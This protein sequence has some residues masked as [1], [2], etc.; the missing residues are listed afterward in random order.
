MPEPATAPY[1]GDDDHRPIDWGGLEVTPAPPIQG[2]EEPVPVE[3]EGIQYT[4]G[5]QVQCPKCDRTV[6]VTQA[7]KL[8]SHTCR[9]V[10]APPRKV[11]SQTER[12]KRRGA[13][14]S[15]AVREKCVLVLTG[16]I[17]SGAELA[18]SRYVPCPGSAVPSEISEPEDMVG[19]LVDLLWPLLPKGAQRAVSLIAD[20][21]DLIVMAIAWWEWGKT[22]QQWAVQQHA[23]VIA[24]AEEHTQRVDIHTYAT[25]PPTV[26]EGGEFNGFEVPTLINE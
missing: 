23:R 5:S 25:Q 20:E 1:D 21:S 18:I 8:Y 7:G 10:E 12:E 15:R 4:P 22:L 14:P 9:K 19:P 26:T 24:E 13:A 11:A 16:A 3:D 6:K 2:H 17:E